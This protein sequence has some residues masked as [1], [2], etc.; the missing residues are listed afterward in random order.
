MLMIETGELME[1]PKTENNN[2]YSGRFI[3]SWYFGAMSRLDATEMLM[4][5]RECGVFLVRD[6][7]THVGDY[8]LSGN[9]I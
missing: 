1:W 8:V 4:Q 2:R 6:S 3:C 5:E 9:I 7:R